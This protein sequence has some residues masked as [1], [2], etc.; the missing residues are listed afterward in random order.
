MG[1][2]ASLLLMTEAPAR[3]YVDPGSGLLTFQMLGASLAGWLF[4]VRHKL[5]TILGARPSKMETV[6]LQANAVE[7]SRPEQSG[8]DLKRNQS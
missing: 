4:Y 6:D 1:L 2:L 8:V 7:L 5:K 3:A